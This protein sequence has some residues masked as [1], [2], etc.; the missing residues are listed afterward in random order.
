MTRRAALAVRLDDDGT[1]R[2]E[3]GEFPERTRRRAATAVRAVLQAVVDA[4]AEAP[5]SAQEWEAAWLPEI[6]RRV[7]ELEDGRAKTVPLEA[8]LRRISAAAR[9][10]R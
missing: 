7:R 5:L 1:L 4:E 3:L 2:A 6:E 10:T 9:G 8:A